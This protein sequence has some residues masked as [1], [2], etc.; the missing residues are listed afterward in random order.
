MS[1]DTHNTAT[2]QHSSAPAQQGITSHPDFPRVP[3]SHPH[4]QSDFP[5]VPPSHPPGQSG[6]PRVP[7]PYPPGL[8]AGPHAFAFGQFG[9]PGYVHTPAASVQPPGQSGAHFSCFSQHAAAPNDTSPPPRMETTAFV[10]G[11]PPREAQRADAAAA[12]AR[13]TPPPQQKHRGGGDAAT[14]AIGDDD[15]AAE[16]TA[17]K[18]RGR[19]GPVKRGLKPKE[20]FDLVYIADDIDYFGPGKRG[21]KDKALGSAA[22]ACKTL[23]QLSD[24]MFRA[25]SSG[26]A[27]QGPKRTQLDSSGLK[28]LKR[29]RVSKVIA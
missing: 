21:D 2:P 4:G 14:N 23:P 11:H 12:R 28:R 7:P 6:F 8:T 13:V 1:H 5:R 10:G 27:A 16:L 22:R 19:T 25:R 9:V 24:G 17:K 3:P 20:C 29:S 26:K 15:E 18:P